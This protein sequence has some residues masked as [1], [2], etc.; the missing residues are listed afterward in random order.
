MNTACTVRLATLKDAEGICRVNRE[1]LGYDHPYEA[2]YTQLAA[3]LTRET[4]RVFVAE[5]DGEIVGC[6]HASDFTTLYLPPLK[7]IVGLAVS[8]THQRRG[9]G[10][11]LLTAAEEWAK[12]DGAKGV[13]LVSGAARLGAHEFYKRCGYTHMKDQKNFRKMF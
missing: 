7:D 2:V 11:K 3:L 6:L 13:R 12:A 8:A 4:D 5:L 10:R 1:D 9:I